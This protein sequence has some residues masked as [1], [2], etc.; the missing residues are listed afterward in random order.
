MLLANLSLVV[1]FLAILFILL[2]GLRYVTSAGNPEKAKLARAG[3]IHVVIGV[4]IIV[5]TFF[6]VKFAVNIG[7]RLVTGNTN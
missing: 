5:C 1:G 4:I 6:I 2:S 3:L 7:Q